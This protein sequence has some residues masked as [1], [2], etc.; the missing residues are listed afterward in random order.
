MTLK[1]LAARN[2][3]HQEPRDEQEIGNLINAAIARLQDAQNVSLSYASRFDLAYNAAHGFALAALR[4]AGYRTDKR[5]LVF[6]C[7]VHTTSLSKSTVRLFSTCHD[8]RNLAEYTGYFDEDFPLL[9]AL[10]KSTV[11]LGEFLGNHS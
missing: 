1:N 10:I 3:L 8:K 7:L 4:S 11:E 9:D 5:Y 2:L 6:Q